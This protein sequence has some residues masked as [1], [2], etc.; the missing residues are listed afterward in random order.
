MIC[1]RSI[2]C[3]SINV[4]QKLECLGMCLDHPPLPPPTPGVELKLPSGPI[5]QVL[6]EGQHFRLSV[7]VYC[8]E[9]DKGPVFHFVH[10]GQE[11]VQVGRRTSVHFED[12]LKGV[13]GV[14][15]DGTPMAPS[16]LGGTVK[17][18]SDE[19]WIAA[20]WKIS[21]DACLGLACQEQLVLTTLDKSW[22]RCS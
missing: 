13:Q 16:V 12:P 2:A 4:V 11:G 15:V 6:L 5:V 18:R 20:S 1:Y 9:P 8:L 21:R 3:Q 10:S 19:Q 22:K 14:P 7:E 17:R